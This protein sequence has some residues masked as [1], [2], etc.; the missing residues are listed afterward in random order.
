MKDYS[1]F[2]IN[3]IGG[4]VSPGTLQNILEAAKLAGVREVSFGARQQLLMYVK[5]ETVRGSG[6]LEFKKKLY[7]SNISFEIDSDKKP[8]IISSYCAE[9]VFPTGQWIS[10]GI[11]KTFLMASIMNPN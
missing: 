10:E 2:K 6:I 11:Y 5:A 9:E 7:E 1:L 3:L 8:N 4:I